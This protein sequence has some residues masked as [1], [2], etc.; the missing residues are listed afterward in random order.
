[1]TLLNSFIIIVQ[2][3]ISNF[4]LI[5]G[6]SQPQLENQ[7]PMYVDYDSYSFETSAGNR[8]QTGHVL[9]YYSSTVN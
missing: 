5:N 7:M 2:F 3:S 4:I 8:L 1:M 9:G 6:L